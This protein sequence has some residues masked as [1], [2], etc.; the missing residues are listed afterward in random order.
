L[1]APPSAWT[2]SPRCRGIYIVNGRP[3]LF[4][5]A[6][7][8]VVRRSGKMTKFREWMEGS[9][10]T[11]TAWCELERDGGETL[12]RSF[13]WAQAKRANLAGKGG[14]WTQYPARMLTMRAR[15]FALRDLFADVLS[16]LSND[17]PEPADV[18]SITAHGDE[19][20]PDPTM[21]ARRRDRR[22]GRG[23]A[24]G[25]RYARGCRIVI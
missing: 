6:L 4:G 22:R 23:D 21:I 11:L 2:R 18:G 1:P 20:P 10:E 19:A 14:P 17:M 25:S 5:D 24:A 15:N 16:G 8:A 12:K 3:Q 7:L 9:G 13:S